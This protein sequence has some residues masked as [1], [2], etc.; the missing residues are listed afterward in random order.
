LRELEAEWNERY[1]KTAY[2]EEEKHP[3]SKFRSLFP[4]Q[5]QMGNNYD[6]EGQA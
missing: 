1:A 2:F 5:R 6:V 3:L 4:T